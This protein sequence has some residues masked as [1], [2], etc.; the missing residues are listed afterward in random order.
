MHGLTPQNRAE[1]VIPRATPAARNARRASIPS[2]LRRDVEQGS[3]RLAIT[4]ADT[5]EDRALGARLSARYSAVPVE[6]ADVIVVVGGNAAVINALHRFHHHRCPI[7]PLTPG[8]TGFLTNQ[9]DTDDLLARIRN[10]QTAELAP[11]Q[12]TWTTVAGIS[13]RALAFNEVALFRETRR[14]THIRITIDDQ[15]RLDELVGDGVLVATPAGSSAYNLSAHGPILPIGTRLLALTP[16]AAFRPRQWRGALLPDRVS[17]RFDVL[18][19]DLGPT[20][21]AADFVEIRDVAQAKV[22]LRD[23]DRALLLLDSNHSMDERLMREQFK[24]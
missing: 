4:T 24:G 18:Q 14:M 10:A 16:I 5:P 2:A 15:V 12:L 20:S 21:T 7:F 8:Y 9:H 13:G 23:D 1:K 17:V 22:R 11:L 19:P 6:N 3:L